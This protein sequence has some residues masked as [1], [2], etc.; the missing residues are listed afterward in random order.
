MENQHSTSTD[1]KHT[2][3]HLLFFTILSLLLSSC[4]KEDNNIDNPIE[5]SKVVEDIC[6]KMDD[7]NFINFCYTNFDIDKDGKVS[8]IEADAVSEV[9]ITAKE[10]SS[11]TGVEY[12]TNITVL[13]CYLNELTSLNV[14]GCIH[15]KTLYCMYNRLTSLDVS[16]C[17]NLERLDCSYNELMS[18]NIS[19]C[20]NLTSL[21]CHHNALT[22]LDVSDCVNLSV[23]D[24]KYN[25]LTS[26]DVSG[27]VNLTMLYCHHNELTSLDVSSCAELSKLDCSNNPLTILY[28][29][30]KSTWS[31]ISYPEGVNKE[32][33]AI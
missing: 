24:C 2:F 21:N 25:K 18:L 12:F 11:L 32:S 17:T 19:G 27:C 4:A 14:S 20:A 22:S 8:M 3:I 26:L 10:I 28:L 15:L 1:M 5:E 23:L 31:Y 6:T 7:I 9:R 29:N 33:K 30:A 16:G 13:E